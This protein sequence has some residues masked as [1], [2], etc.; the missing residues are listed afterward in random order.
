MSY[1][2]ICSNDSFHV[3]KIESLLVQVG[4]EISLRE[5]SLDPGPYY[6]HLPVR[7]ERERLLAHKLADVS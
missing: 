7:L 6:L 5:D 2:W 4:P 3:R 1:D